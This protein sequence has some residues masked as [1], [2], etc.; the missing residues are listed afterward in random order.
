MSDIKFKLHSVDE[1]QDWPD[2][3]WLIQGILPDKAFVQVYG[4]WRSGKT[5]IVLDWALTVATGESWGGLHPV[6]GG[7]V[8]YVFGEGRAGI[9][10]RVNAWLDHHGYPRRNNGI[11]FLAVD[12]PPQLVNLEDISQFCEDVVLQMDH[13]PRLIIF[14]TMA[15]AT[16]GVDE[17]MTKEMGI[18]VASADYL[19]KMFDCTVLV[20]HHTGKDGH[21]SRGSSSIPAGLDADIK[22]TRKDDSRVVKVV[23]EKMKD[24]E[25]FE[26]IAVTLVD[27]AERRE[28]GSA[29]S[30]VSTLGGVVPVDTLDDL[31]AP[32][33]NARVLLEHLIEELPSGGMGFTEIRDKM[34]DSC[35]IPKG[36]FGKA[37]GILENLKLVEKAGPMYL[38]TDQALRLFN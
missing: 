1:I 10:Q 33:S 22:T 31:L 5:F 38:V 15:R 7:P 8:L 27:S 26:P 17:N 37:L 9:K 4:K 3:E 12:H 30:L 20:V 28:D 13:A 25:E 11:P 19:R 29:A 21:T 36:S 18:V 34:S 14:D 6:K 23:C 32:N 24:G 35:R 2:P 16:V